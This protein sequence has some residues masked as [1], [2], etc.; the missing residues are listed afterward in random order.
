MSCGFRRDGP[1]GLFGRRLAS[2]RPS[3]EAPSLGMRSTMAGRAA[4]WTKY[5]NVSFPLAS[6][7]CCLEQSE[8]IVRLPSIKVS[9]G[10]F[11]VG[12]YEF[13]V[14]ARNSIGPDPRSLENKSQYATDPFLKS[15]LS[16][17]GWGEWSD[18]VVVTL[19]DPKWEK[20]QGR[21]AETQV[22]IIPAT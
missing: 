4:R 19:H 14:R 15:V 20:Q 12:S 2:V 7:L 13:M 11:P 16:W 9:L 5:A 21:E 6:V 3:G 17:Q 22:R 18:V 8:R 1:L 10:P